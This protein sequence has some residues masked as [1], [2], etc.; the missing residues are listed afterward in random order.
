M[1]V[2]EISLSAFTSVVVVVVMMSCTPV[3]KNSA[4]SEVENAELAAPD[5]KVAGLAACAAAASDVEN[6]EIG[7]AVAAAVLV[8]RPSN[9]AMRTGRPPTGAM[10]P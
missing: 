2:V 6:A 4:A 7:A 8:E 10:Q 5:A 1:V 3:F 9:E